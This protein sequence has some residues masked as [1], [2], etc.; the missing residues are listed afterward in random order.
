MILRFLFIATVAAAAA[1]CAPAAEEPAERS[2]TAFSVRPVTTGVVV[3]GVNAP[4]PAGA[5]GTANGRICDFS[6][7]E[8][9]QTGQMTGASVQC[10]A[11]GTLNQVLAHLPATFN[12][13]CMADAGRLQG[14]L[15]A[16]SVRGNP[17]HC[18]L[19]G[20]TPSDAQTRFGGGKWR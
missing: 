5:S 4:L 17:E 13:Y 11:G 18:D 1:N 3:R 19:S 9:S 20:I 14:R 7:E 6:R 10:L 15:I 2:A 8:V 16:A 12:S